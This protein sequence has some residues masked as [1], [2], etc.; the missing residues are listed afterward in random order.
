M[1]EGAADI[2][3]IEGLGRGRG[4]QSHRG[5]TSHAISTGYTMQRNGF[6]ATALNLAVDV[7]CSISHISSGRIAICGTPTYYIVIGRRF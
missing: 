1:K 4:A 7:L 6:V 2:P 3:T 5:E